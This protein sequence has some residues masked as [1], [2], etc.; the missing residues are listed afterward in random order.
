MEKNLKQISKFMSL[1]LRHKPE[2]IGLHLDE[3]GWAAVDELIE[4]M[5]E[6]GAGVDKAIIRQI[7]DTNDKKRF[8]FNEDQSRI[9]ASQGHSI[10]VDLGLEPVTPPD[11][12][13]HGTAV[14]FLEAILQDGL[15][16]QN[17]QHVHL[18]ALKETAIAVG[19]RHGKPVVLEVNASEMTKAGYEFYLSANNVWLVEIVLP[20]YISVSGH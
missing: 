6:K 18:T 16:K 12:L 17:R 20:E 10:D 1:V 15:L 7:V 19:S 5:N 3:Q 9:R 2:T 4:K 13:Y 11:I 8:A 14:R